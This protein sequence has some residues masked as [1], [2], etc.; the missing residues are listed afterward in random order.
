MEDSRC[1][2]M[3]VDRRLDVYQRRAAAG[4]WR[5]LAR[6]SA[7]TGPS[8]VVRRSAVRA[9]TGTDDIAVMPVLTCDPGADVTGD[10]ILNPAAL[11]L[12]S[13]GTNGNYIM[14]SVRSPG[15]IN[16]DFAVFKNFRMGGSRKFQFR[17]A[18]TN[19]FNHPQRFFD[20][21]VNL[22]LDYTNGVMTNQNFGILPQR[23]QVRPPH[24][25][26]GVQVL[27]LAW[28]RAPSARDAAASESQRE[29]PTLC[30]SPAHRD[31]GGFKFSRSRAPSAR[32]AAASSRSAN[33]RP[34]VFYWRR[35]PSARDAA[36][37]ESRRESPTLSRSPAHRD[38]GGFTFF[39]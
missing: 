39:C 32:D 3:A 28:R 7:S 8:P 37:S 15:Y 27:L 34:Q 9:C 24:R 14:P 36:A 35:A 23:Q 17:A 1:W 12:P 30:R 13:I 5:R 11:P 6:T 33:R 19:V 10:Q 38:G 31:G 18:F 4:R 25:P 26:A 16:H 2:G 20:D 21:N 29:S 22:N